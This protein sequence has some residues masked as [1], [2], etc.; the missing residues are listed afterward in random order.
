MALRTN[1]DQ[2]V[3]IFKKGRKKSEERWFVQMTCNLL[4]PRIYG[5]FP[6][7]ED[8]KLF[9]DEAEFELR[10]LLDFELRIRSGFSCPHGFSM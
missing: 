1:A 5:P 10:K 6:T 8:A 9:Q 4:E 2:E 7:E 3:T